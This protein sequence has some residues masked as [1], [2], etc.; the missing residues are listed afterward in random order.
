MSFFVIINIRSSLS[1]G[2]LPSSISRHYTRSSNQLMHNKSFAK[3]NKLKI[4]WQ[5]I[6]G[7]IQSICLNGQ[8]SSYLQNNVGVLYGAVLFF[9]EFSLQTDSLSSCHSKLLKYADD[10]VLCNSY[11]KFPDQEGLNDKLYRIATWSADRV[12]IKSKT[13]CV[14]CHFCQA[15]ILF[16]ATLDALRHIDLFLRMIQRYI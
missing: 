11:S 14:E 3:P 2:N 4:C 1:Q 16:Y 10:F 5:F 13:K 15:F 6:L 9:F 12:L 7:H 8:C